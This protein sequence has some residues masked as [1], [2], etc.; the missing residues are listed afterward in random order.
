MSKVSEFQLIVK[1]KKLVAYI[2]QI[3]EKS[4]K[5]FRF[6][7]L[8]KIHTICFELIEL[9]YEV[10]SIKLGEVLRSE[11]QKAILTKFK[12]LIYLIEVGKDFKCFTF[13]QFEVASSFMIVKR[14]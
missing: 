9:T 12:I 13:H 1:M 11:K 5:K 7:L 8:S 4:P 10:N 6:S 3:S 14:P 2:L